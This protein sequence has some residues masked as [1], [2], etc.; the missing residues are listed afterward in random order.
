[1]RCVLRPCGAR[2]AGL[3]TISP[4]RMRILGM[5]T[6]D[7]ALPYLAC[8][9]PGHATCQ[10]SHPL[11]ATL[12]PPPSPSHMPLLFAQN[13]PRE[14][15][16]ALFLR[17]LCHPI[18]IDIPARSGPVPHVKCALPTQSQQHARSMRVVAADGAVLQTSTRIRQLI[19]ILIWDPS[20]LT[21]SGWRRQNW[22]IGASYKGSPQ[23]PAFLKP[24]IG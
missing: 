2:Q 12:H 21:D 6:E 23:D 24:G 5:A 9:H 10:A 4:E 1:M 19:Y 14:F 7:G 8:A 3:C 17:S 22:N 16:T 18:S 15:P 11:S 20:I 13:A